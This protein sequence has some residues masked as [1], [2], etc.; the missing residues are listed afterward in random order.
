[1]LT[2]KAVYILAAGGNFTGA[3]IFAAPVNV[4]DGTLFISAFLWLFLTKAET[5]VRT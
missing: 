2:D 1:M 4:P 5:A 3:T